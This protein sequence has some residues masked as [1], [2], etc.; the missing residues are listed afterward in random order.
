VRFV[1]YALPALLFL[2][3]VVLFVIDPGTNGI[4][5]LAMAAGAALSLLLLNWLY[6]VSVDGSADRSREEAARQFFDRH[7]RWP[8]E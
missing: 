5:G 7:G 3:G 6:R 1:R 2:V 8:D 4:H